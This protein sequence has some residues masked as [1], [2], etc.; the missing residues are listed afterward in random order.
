MTRADTLPESLTAKLAAQHAQAHTAMT[1][2]LAQTTLQSEALANA[3][4]AWIDAD[5]S[6]ARAFD[7]MRAWEDA[8]GSDPNTP[9]RDIIHESA[10]RF[11]LGLSNWAIDRQHTFDECAV[12]WEATAERATAA[13]EAL[14]TAACALGTDNALEDAAELLVKLSRLIADTRHAS[15]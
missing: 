9:C 2:W 8:R 14:W 10:P 1:R 13:S 7:A 5:R 11:L 6:H 15:L 3:R 4:N 12:R